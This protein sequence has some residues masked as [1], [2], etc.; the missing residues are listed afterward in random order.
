MIGDPF[1]CFVHGLARGWRDPGVYTKTREQALRY[2]TLELKQIPGLFK[3]KN[4]IQQLLMAK[5]PCCN[6]NHRQRNLDQRVVVF[7]IPP[8]KRM[9]RCVVRTHPPMTKL[10]F[11]KLL[12]NRVFFWEFCSVIFVKDVYHFSR[13]LSLVAYLSWL[14]RMLSC[15]FLTSLR[16][17]LEFI[18]ESESM[19]S[20]Y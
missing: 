8:A 10:V 9:S 12:E 13:C 1:P 14:S 11:W 7:L 17:S 2:L 18:Y 6:S 5:F 19:A 3:K 16:A 4:M 15:L 20:L